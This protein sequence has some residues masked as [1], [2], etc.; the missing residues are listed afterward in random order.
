MLWILTL[1]NALISFLDIAA[2]ATLLFVIRIYTQPPGHLHYPLPGWTYDTSSVMPILLF[3]LFFTLKNLGAYLVYRRQ[4]AFVYDVAARISRDQLSRYLD[5]D[6][7]NYVQVPQSV[8]TR[9]INQQPIEFGHHIL[10]GLQQIFSE[11]MLALISIVAI[12]LFNTK[13]F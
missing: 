2:L 1:L 3:V 12:L 8:H 6:Y 10:L 4:V 11:G 5:G 13:I 9:H 7:T